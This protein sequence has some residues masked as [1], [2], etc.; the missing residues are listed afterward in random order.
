MGYK[1]NSYNMAEEATLPKTQDRELTCK[2][3]GL[4][5]TGFCG[6]IFTVIALLVYLYNF[7]DNAPC[8]AKFSIQSIAL[9]PSSATWHVDFLVKN[10]SS[11]YSILY[12]SDETGVRLGP[13]NAAVLNTS[14]E[15]KSP[16]HTAFSVDF[17]AEG[18]PDVVLEQLDIKLR[19]KHK[20]YGES[21]NAGH[22]DIRCH[23]LTRS[24]ENVEKIHCHSSF[25]KLKILSGNSVSVSNANVSAADWRIGFVARSPVTGCEIS[26]HPLSSRLLRGSQ[27]ISNPSSPSPLSLGNSTDIVFEKVVMPQVTGDVIW[28]LRVE[29]MY[30][31]K[32][33]TRY[34][35]G[36][37]TAV[38]PDIPVKFTTDPAGKMTGSL[39]GNMRR[40]EHKLRADLA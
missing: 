38:C 10:P 8:D 32:T 17:V 30:A 24:H 14:N 21:D 4:V 9:S 34:L 28:D 11:R 16:S 36:L 18:N 23:N 13:L 6:G 12:G 31:M 19:A 39:L 25:T 29:I 35:R 1:T 2:E 37:L 3:G 15:R 40:C 20:N 7:V 22:V 5:C 33:S 27:V 26:L